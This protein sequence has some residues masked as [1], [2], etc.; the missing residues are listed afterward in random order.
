MIYVKFE[1][2]FHP[3]LCSHFPPHFVFHKLIKLL[4]SPHFTTC[5]GTAKSERLKQNQNK[6][7]K[8][9]R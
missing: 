6:E 2:Y 7:I 8:R 5:Y 4:P 3:P 9:Y 1:W